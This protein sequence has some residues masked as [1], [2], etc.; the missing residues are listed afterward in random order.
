M[1]TVNNF[2]R[3]AFLTLIWSVFGITTIFN[4]G[5][6]YLPDGFPS[7]A[8]QVGG[9]LVVYALHTMVNMLFKK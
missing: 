1:T 2:F 5:Q 6:S 3:I 9:F 4:M 8:V 7:L